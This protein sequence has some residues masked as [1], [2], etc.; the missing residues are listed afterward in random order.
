MTEGEKNQK[1]VYCLRV[2][3]AYELTVLYFWSQFSHFFRF[4]S[5]LLTKDCYKGLVNKRISSFL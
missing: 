2:S 4:H 3:Y 5:G 1:S